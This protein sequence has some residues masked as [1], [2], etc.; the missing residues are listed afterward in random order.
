MN[1]IKDYRESELKQY[2]I[3]NVL[4]FLL[5]HD[6]LN[7]NDAKNIELMQKVVSLLS[8][9]MLSSV[10]FIFTLLVDCM[11]SSDLKSL[12]INLYFGKSP[13]HKVF[14]TIKDKN[15]DNRFTTE[16]ALERYSDIYKNMPINQKERE[17]YEN[18]KWYDIYNKY[19]DKTMV[20]ISNRDY[21]LMRDMCITT[22]ILLLIYFV[23]LLFFPWLK[24]NGQYI[25][26]LVIMIISTFIATH[27]KAKRFVYNVITIDIREG[28]KEE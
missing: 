27:V 4:V 3:A 20:Y 9:T 21:L 26:F 18:D 5:I 25:V 13:G 16:K 1:N 7:F 28:K 2:V 12:I 23:A 19:R 24:F 6:L 10:I 11:I 15:K 17:K 22:V 14:S 8:I